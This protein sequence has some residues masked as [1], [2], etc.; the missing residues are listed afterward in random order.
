MTIISRPNASNISRVMVSI[1]EYVN[2]G[3]WMF[4]TLTVIVLLELMA[5]A[6][7]ALAFNKRL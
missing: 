2:E 3:D 7:A 4:V 1:A 5:S 6:V